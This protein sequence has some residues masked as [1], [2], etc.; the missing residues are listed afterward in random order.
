MS[1]IDRLIIGLRR[2]LL[3][4]KWSNNRIGVVT[5]MIPTLNARLVFH[6]RYYPSRIV[7]QMAIQIAMVHRITVY[8]RNAQSHLMFKPWMRK[9]HNSIR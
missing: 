7:D 9:G 2:S 6:P 8:R 4:T 5:Y 1:H 3:C